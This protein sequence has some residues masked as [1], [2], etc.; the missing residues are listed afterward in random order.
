MQ[1]GLPHGIP[2]YGRTPVCDDFESTFVQQIFVI[3]LGFVY[4]N[5]V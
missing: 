1:N 2:N 4:G 3:N 5:I